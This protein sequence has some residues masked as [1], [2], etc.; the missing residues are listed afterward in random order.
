[1]NQ[2]EQQSFIDFFKDNQMAIDVFKKKYCVCDSDISPEA[3][4]RRVAK[5]LS[6]YEKNPEEWEERWVQE[7]L[8]DW[9]R[10]GGSILSGVS[11]PSKVSL[12]N[13]TTIGL[14]EDTIDSISD[15]QRKMMKCA[16]ARQG[17]GVDVS[18][19]RPK[20]AKINNASNESGGIVPWMD[21]LQGI[22]KYVGQRGRMPAIL[23]SVKDSHPDIEEFIAC[24]QDSTAITNANISVQISDRFMR[25]VDEDDDSWEL[26]FQTPYEIIR[27][28]THVRELM[29]KIAESACKTAEPGVQFI[30]KARD[31]SMV[32]QIYKATGDER[33]KVISTNACLPPEATVFRK[34][35]YDTENPERLIHSRGI[36][37][38]GALDIG[39]EIWTGSKWSKVINKVSRGIKPIYRYITHVGDF[40][41]T[42]DHNVI[43]KGRK[44]EVGKCVSIDVAT[45]DR[46]G[47]ITSFYP[48]DIMYGFMMS[49][50]KDAI[51]DDNHFYNRP[52]GRIASV[53]CGLVSTFGDVS[54]SG[55]FIYIDH[56][57]L[58][59]LKRVQ[60]MLSMLGI[61][62]TL[63]S[64]TDKT[65]EVT[66]AK[67][68][69]GRDE[70]FSRT[71][72]R[73]TIKED[74]YVFD[75]KV[76]FIQE[77]KQKKLENILLVSDSTV[78]SHLSKS[79]NIIKDENGN[80]GRYVRDG[81]VFDITIEDSSHVFW[82]A[83]LSVCNCSEK[84][85]ADSS[86]C[87]LASINMG[88]FSTNEDEYKKE[89]DRIVPSLVRLMDDAIEYEI[90]HDLSAI[91]EQKW[92]VQHTREIGL[93]ITNV[94]GWFIKQG[95]GYDSNEAI[96]A[97]ERFFS[98]YMKVAF[99]T[100][101][102]LAKEKGP[103]KVYDLFPKE[104][105]HITLSG[106]S[107]YRNITNKFFNGEEIG[108]LRNLAIGSI[109]PTG[110]LSMTFSKP[111]LSSGIEPAISAYYW[112]K[113]RALSGNNSW[114]Y[115][116]CFP[117]T[118]KNLLMEMPEFSSL[119]ES[120]QQIIKLAPESMK[121]QDGKK[122]M[123]IVRII[124]PLLKKVQFKP[125]HEID[126]FQKL[127]MMSRI[128]QWL[129]S[130][131]SV[132]YNLPKGTSPELIS[133]LYIDAWKNDVRAVSVYVDGSREGILI[134]EPP[135]KQ[136]DSK[137]ETKY[138]KE[139]P[140]LIQ[141]NCAPKREKRLP[142]DIHKC[143]VKGKDWLVLVGLHEGYPYEIFAGEYNKDVMYIPS[144]ISTGIIEKKGKGMYSLS[145]ENGI[146]YN[147]VA[148]TLMNE[149]YRSMTRMI[150]LSLR[151]GVRPV[152]II[153]QIRK[154][155]EDIT[156]FSSAVIRILNKYIKALDY[157]YLAKHTGF[158][159]EFCGSENAVYNGGCVVCAECG[160]G[161]KC[162]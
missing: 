48:E 57:S 139:R 142:C 102:Q 87:N 129:D 124:E 32:H 149:R 16:A 118:V 123:E 34:E 49:H 151:H 121:D 85:L 31:G 108:K 152:Y 62:S 100:S 141:F 58:N 116:F 40:Y 46:S 112:R 2:S 109:A 106:S 83:G 82:N 162:E 103:A 146:E 11:N 75:R 43:S 133:K 29:N 39:D 117:A 155:N 71:M 45:G 126:P 28:K 55:Y 7:M 80:T 27:K 19:I 138:C 3:V 60:Q 99:E 76:W 26:Y 88:R 8:D 10:P 56:V 92:I 160:K 132:T 111:V 73:I 52:P 125:A 143:K 25:K 153:D 51:I 20:G 114:E 47:K 74:I 44:N 1:M 65:G 23:L 140:E 61:V 119:L 38:I 22:A 17:L 6:Q 89:I 63:T 78:T 113:T 64:Y 98:Y 30:D 154:S 12:A 67:T 15:T 53:L 21:Y 134:F 68:I 95:F 72:Y 69:R 54:E 136:Q 94:H 107:F 81:E 24:K 42:K 145:L 77:Y 4:F 130:A 137:E 93:G 158:K 144:S 127:K 59:L 86:I 147:D 161:S 131:C 18:N 101:V 36:T 5:G 33:F 50:G 91:P 41:G 110:T 13:C 157:T 148:S 156:E 135:T 37:T 105:N 104:M 120:E 84:F 159:C 79:Y 9:Y 97:I 115:F 70:L 122:G 90:Q 128:Y 14:K 35:K 96:D 66:K 150:S